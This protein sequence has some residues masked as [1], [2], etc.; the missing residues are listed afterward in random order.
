MSEPSEFRP[1]PVSVAEVFRMA[2]GLA[3][4]LED[5]AAQSPEN[6]VDY[7]RDFQRG[8]HPARERIAEL[9][10]AMAEH[11]KARQYASPSS[12]VALSPKSADTYTEGTWGI[13]AE[14][15]YEAYIDLIDDDTRQFSD[16]YLI[17][18]KNG[19]PD[20]R[21]GDARRVV[22]LLNSPLREV[23]TPAIEQ[24]QTVDDLVEALQ[25]TQGMKP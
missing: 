2:E 7:L 17:T 15:N 9:R 3:L 8:H 23:P 22:A 6:I 24:A 16:Y 12:A 10:H 1:R 18:V 19:D 13:V 14:D 11:A 21:D 5:W 4:M 20:E 25:Q